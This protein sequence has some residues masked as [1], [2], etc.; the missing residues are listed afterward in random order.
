[1][2]NTL[3]R[4]KGGITASH[5]KK[6]SEFETVKIP[7]PSRVVIPMLQHIGAPCT[8]LVKKGDSVLVGQK[9]GDS[10]SMISAPVHS[11]VSGV[12]TDVRPMLYP[13]GFEVVS[14]EIEPDGQQKPDDSVVPVKA[15]DR[16]GIIKKIRESGIVGL[17]GAGF[18]T[19]VKLSPP[20]GKKLDT[21]IINGA[22]CEPYI[23][24]DYR[25]MMENSRRVLEGARILMELTQIPEA[26][27]GIESNKP[28]A[29]Q[30][31]SELAREFNGIKVVSLPSRYPQGGEKQL[32]YAVTGRKVPAGGLPSHI[33]VLVHNVNTVSN[34]AEYISTGMPLIKKRVTVEGS[35]VA[36]PMNLEVL[37]GTSL[38]DVFEFCGG[39]KEKPAKI[40]MGGPMM[41]VAQFSLDNPV[42]KHT[43]ALLALTDK[44]ANT[45]R[46]GVC[47]RCGKCVSACPMGLMPLYISANVELGRVEE[48]LKYHLNDC[49]ECG[50]CSY[51]CPASRY[52]VQSIRYAKAELKR[53]QTLKAG[54][55]N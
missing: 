6:T 13:G 50:C 17:G 32:I 20:P 38:K 9:I 33:G 55:G 48:T 49:I 35:A 24:S 41:G 26:Y 45:A 43:N 21:L 18:P 7:L 28:K 2:I 19:S 29:I 40:I 3:K 16:E 8:P 4:F 5:H 14:A 46:E 25:E 23:T 54:G 37:I 47:I 30:R 11:S 51:V 1:M 36:K 44:E 27:I 15:A 12:V 34:I 10:D 42:V 53:R 39:F 31:L 52:L 22:E